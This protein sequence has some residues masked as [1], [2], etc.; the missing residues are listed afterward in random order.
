MATL[1]V[2][3]TEALTLNGSEQGGTV[4]RPASGV[5]DIYKRIVSCPD[6]VPLGLVTFKS[7]VVTT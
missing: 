4:A 1:T 6:D 3:L 2:T 7:T 5:N